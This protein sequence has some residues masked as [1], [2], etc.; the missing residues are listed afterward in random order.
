[1]NE[2]R[3][4]NQL[5][6]K[7]TVIVGASGSGKTMLAK[8]I[9]KKRGIPHIE[10]DELYWDLNWTKVPDDEF[11]A[12]IDQALS[13]ASWI[14]DGN[15][16]KVRDLTWARADTIVWLDY[17]L[18]LVLARLLRRTLWYILTGKK[19]SHGNK[20]SVKNLF[21]RRSII[22]WM[23]STYGNKKKRYQQ[24]EH[25]PNYAHIQV[26]RLCSPGATNKWLE[27]M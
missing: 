24:I 12:R 15:Y 8:Q 18:G 1:M 26:V 23:L 2:N 3:Q 20:E 11:R 16:S 4:M 5:S 22:L 10:L 14:T 21:S 27:R 6:L 17:S 13:R 19:H 7:R 9:A 25:D